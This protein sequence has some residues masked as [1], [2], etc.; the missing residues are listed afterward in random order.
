M[1]ERA[2]APWALILLILTG[3]SGKSEP[4]IEGQRPPNIPAVMPD[5][6][7]S[8]P[9][10]TAEER[11]EQ[12]A[13]RLKQ[14]ADATAE[15]KYDTAIDKL[16]EA[17][18]IEPKDRK[19]HLEMAKLHQ[20]KS[21]A[22]VESDLAG[23]YYTML[24]AANYIRTLREYYPDQTAEEKAL[25]PE[26]YFDVATFE[27]MAPRVEETTAA[28]NEAIGAGFK[29]FDRIRDDPRWKKMLD[30]PLFQKAFPDLAKKP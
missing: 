8:K 1:P 21:R 20:A 22:I 29:D 3:C 6:R 2:V 15:K 13:D 30:Q 27:A 18:M 17:I 7:P 9:V 19:V 5:A 11:A 24:S 28:L 14:A 4:L 26:I 16:R 10:G 25:A 12:V 23:S